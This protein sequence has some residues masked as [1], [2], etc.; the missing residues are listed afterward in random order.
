MAP[1]CRSFIIYCEK[2]GGMNMADFQLTQRVGVELDWALDWRPYLGGA[3]AISATF[4]ILDNDGA[5]TMTAQ[6]NDGNKT[7]FTIQGFAAERIYHVSVSIVP[8]SNAGIDPEQVV[9][10]YISP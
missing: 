9:E 3:S 1:A 10:V 5:L 8:S 7:G 2:C 6:E 4:T